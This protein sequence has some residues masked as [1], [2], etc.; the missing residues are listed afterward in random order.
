MDL[1]V[2]LERRRE[3]RR[4]SSVEH[5]VL[6][7]R[8]RPGHTV[9]LI[10]ISTH[11]AQLET[12]RRLLPGASVDLLLAL[13]VGGLVVRSRV[14]RCSVSR[15][16]SSGVRYRGAVTFEHR[17]WWSR[18]PEYALPRCELALAFERP[19]PH[20]PEQGSSG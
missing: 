4:V 2:Q 5:G 19:G 16:E 9:V 7:A 10:D 8:V 6:T 3:R 12:E 11:G 14:L 18:T 15:V 13:Q 1:M 20:Y 17:I